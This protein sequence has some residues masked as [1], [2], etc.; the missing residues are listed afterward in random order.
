M[1]FFINNLIFQT[2][3][4]FLSEQTFIRLLCCPE[5]FLV[6]RKRTWKRP[7]IAVCFLIRVSTQPLLIFLFFIVP[8]P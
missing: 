8:N 7:F 5:M 4:T 2:F 3:S 6:C 1:I